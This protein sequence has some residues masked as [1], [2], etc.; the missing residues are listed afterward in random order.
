MSY[1]DGVFNHVIINRR[2]S[3]LKVADFLNQVLIDDW[4]IS[5]CE[6]EFELLHMLYC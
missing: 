4:K 5:G 2:G 6:E 1:K 3:S